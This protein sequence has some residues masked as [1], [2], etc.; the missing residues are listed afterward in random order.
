[1]DSRPS[2]TVRRLLRPS[3][4]QVLLTALATLSPTLL[5][6]QQPPPDSVLVLDSL[7][8]SILRVPIA[9]SQVAYAVGVADE[10]ELRLGRS[11]AFL[12]EAL[13]RLVGVRV[14]NRFNFA[15]GER[16]AIRGFGSRAQFGIRG[17]KV[18]VD[19]IPATMP[20]GQSSLDHLDLAT[21]GRA[22]VLRGPGS[23][24]YGNAAGGVLALRT[25]RPFTGDVRQEVNVVAGSH[26]LLDLDAITSGT[27][28]STGYVAGIGHLEY[29]G[30][31]DD[32]TREGDAT[33]GNA[34]RRHFN[35]Q[36]TRE[37]GAGRL[38]LTLNL[39]DLEAENPG[40]LSASDLAESPAARTF[41][42]L[43]RTGKE[44]SQRQLG[45]SWEGPGPGGTAE[46]A[47][48]GIRRSVLNPIPTD[49][50]DLDRVAGGGRV[51]LRGERGTAAGDLH[52]SSGLEIEVQD[53]DR[54]NF[55]N[56]GGEATELTLDQ[57]E[58]VLATGVFTRLALGLAPGIELSGALRY[59]RVRFEAD[60]EL[61]GP[62]NPDDSGERTLDAWS[63][64]VGLVAEVVP[65]L[66]L[67]G[68]VATSLETPTTTELVNR[69]DGGG[70]FNPELDAQRTTGLEAG[71]R[72]IVLEDLDLV[73]GGLGWELTVF[74][75]EIT[76]E[77]VPFEVEEQAGRTFFQNAGRSLHKGVEASLRAE[78]G[79]GVGVHGTWT[80]VD[81]RYEDFE[82]DGEDYSGNRI[83][84]LA[85]DRLQGRLEQ[86]RP[87]W[88]WAAEVE[89][90]G[91]VPVDDA[92]EQ[93]ADAYHL[94]NL[95]AGLRGIAV[96][97][98]SL[99]PFAAVSN[100][101]DE[102]YVAAV[103]VNAFGGRYYE[104]GP[105]RT[106]HVGATLSWSRR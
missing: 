1:M 2:V 78:L 94:T 83:P 69:P 96:A 38:R 52:W 37:L 21:L 79:S 102:S 50:I 22:E 15:V 54:R 35:G 61:V 68:N 31:R 43:Q 47:L 40:S 55:T 56:D 17:V 101:F 63:P 7:Q 48:W 59:D 100:V 46:L 84:G 89:W 90:S 58:R 85:P 26:G 88:F 81:A 92:G 57:D 99:S 8:V 71:A 60:D 45:A 70:G 28:G 33:Y 75:A 27:L 95:R 82:V 18:L 91:E 53:D 39:M 76:D 12:K 77:L 32:P 103:T 34:D 87:D 9:R 6:G 36:V 64:S 44:L 104:P 105:G 16:L 4:F 29:D 14:Q 13:G 30:F 93:T 24:L 74:R 10:D 65:G 98:L 42:V 11:G 62:E 20:D 5:A 23:S 66:T 3:A 106:L 41:N 25:R 49:I 86:T 73:Q 67:W 72:G 80:R 51:L 19:G 97:G